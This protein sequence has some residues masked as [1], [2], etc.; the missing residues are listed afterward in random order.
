MVPF[1]MRFLWHFIC[2]DHWIWLRSVA[3]N[4]TVAASSCTIFHCT[5]THRLRSSFTLPDDTQSKLRPLYKQILVICYHG[6]VH[7]EFRT[8]PAIA[9]TSSGRH[10]ISTTTP[11]NAH[12]EAI[13]KEICEFLLRMK[14]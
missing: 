14:L 13:W 4:L 8:P 10:V 3:C 9:F 11:E 6:L 1:I 7:L 12:H 2:L 5:H